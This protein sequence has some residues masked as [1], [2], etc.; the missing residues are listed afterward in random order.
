M[1][2]RSD[3]FTSKLPRQYKRMLAVAESRGWINGNQQRG[4]IKN[5]LISAHSTHVGFKMKRHN[6][7]NRD[8][9]ESE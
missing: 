3:F 9:T 1:A 7:E 5:S 8:S 6:T 4:E 2:N